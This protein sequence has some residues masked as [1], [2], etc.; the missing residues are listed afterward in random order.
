MTRVFFS[1][2]FGGKRIFILKPVAAVAG[3]RRAGT[4]TAIDI[5]NRFFT[6]A[7]MPIF[8]STYWNII[9]GEKKD[10]LNDAEGLQTM[11]NLAQNLAWFLKI[12]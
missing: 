8:S 9:H 3:A 7:K 2:F 5:I 4:M 11:T 1:S 6:W 12:K 10:A